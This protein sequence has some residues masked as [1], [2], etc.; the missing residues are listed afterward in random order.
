MLLRLTSF[1][2]SYCTR[3][4]VAFTINIIQIR[5]FAN[6]LFLSKSQNERG[7]RTDRRTNRIQL[8]MRPSMGQGRVITSV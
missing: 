3:A 8:I 2:L 6:H 4:F 1:V 7:R 5:T